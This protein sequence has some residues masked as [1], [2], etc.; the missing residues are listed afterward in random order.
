[1]LLDTLRKPQQYCDMSVS[2]SRTLLISF[3]NTV[4]PQVVNI[5]ISTCFEILRRISEL[6]R[7][8]Q[9]ENGYHVN[10]NHHTFCIITESTFLLVCV[11]TAFFQ[12][13]D[14]LTVS[15]MILSRQHYQHISLSDIYHTFW[16]I[17]SLLLKTTA[18]LFWHD[19]C[20]DIP[21][22]TFLTP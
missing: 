21:Q 15:T 5:H 4:L 2:K 10:H 7:L 22:P 18:H 13:Q 8:T 17:T 19:S 3:T 14:L 20:L 16:R 11:A 1:M 9:Q 12:L 6:S